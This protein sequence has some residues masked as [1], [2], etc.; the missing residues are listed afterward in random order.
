MA[1]RAPPFWTQSSP[2]TCGPAALANVL[3]GLG[4]RPA[5]PSRS[6][7]EARIWREAAI[8]ACPGSHPWGLA[9]A[10][11]RRGHRSRVGIEGD[12][13]FLFDHIR[14]DHPGVTRRLYAS[15]EEELR[16]HAGA[17]GARPARDPVAEGVAPG[18]VGLLLVE[19]RKLGHR[20]GG[21]HWVG[22]VDRPGGWTLLDPLARGPR[23]T[24]RDAAWWW[25]HSGYAGTRA[26]IGLES[27]RPE[28]DRRTDDPATRP[29]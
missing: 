28:G 24:G 12:R 10:S 21:P 13:P 8:L 26:W 5:A 18:S 22:W 2:F 14:S 6:L 9:V 7:E 11:G 23:P 16:R 20:S 25:R 29:A 27:G 3:L 4:W 19:A 17:L 1:P 15:V